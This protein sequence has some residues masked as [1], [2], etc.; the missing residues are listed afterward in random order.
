MSEMGL[1]KVAFMTIVS[2]R[3]ALIIPEL[4]YE[5]G[6]FPEGIF[7]TK[8]ERQGDGGCHTRSVVKR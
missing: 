4:T 6:F 1:K 5:F 7:D 2:Y 3:T 8:R